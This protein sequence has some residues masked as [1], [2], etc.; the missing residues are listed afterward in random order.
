[1]DVVKT[2]IERIGGSVDLQSRAGHGTTFRIKIPL[3]LAIVPAL[4]VSSGEDRYA[5]PQSSLLE[6]VRLEADDAEKAI[7]V[8]HGTPVYRLRGKLLPLVYLD[9]ELRGGDTWGDRTARAQNIVV[10]HA[11]EKAFGLVVH[12]IRDTQ[13]I[14]VKPLGQWLKGLTIFAGATI[15][16]D[17]RVALILDVMG[18][19]QRVG[20]VGESHG[21]RHTDDGAVADGRKN[22][23]SW[24]LFMTDDGRRMAIPLDQVARLE[25]WDRTRLERLGGRW[26]VQYRGEILPLCD[27]TAALPGGAGGNGVG[28]QTVASP[29]QNV[30]VVVYNERGRHVGLMVGKILDIVEE[31]VTVSV[32]GS[33]DCQLGLSR[34]GVLRGTVTEL[35]DLRGLFGEAMP[36][37]HNSLSGESLS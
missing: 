5:I 12:A 13:E 34:C 32:G 21:D 33:A 4:I 16:G 31:A 20:V 22:K 11:D 27:L 18:L 10:L 24:L 30:D 37:A 35:P 9:A 23:Q 1:M 17:G 36:G 29:S 28:G 3:T 8:I 15:M 19:A 2:N 25:V 6:L 7:E 26:V 14:V